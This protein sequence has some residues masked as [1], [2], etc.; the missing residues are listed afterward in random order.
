VANQS[1]YKAAGGELDTVLRVHSFAPGTQYSDHV[2]TDKVASYGIASLVALVAGTKLVKAAGAGAF[3]VLLKK[4]GVVIVGAGA[5]LL[6]WLKRL[7][8]RKSES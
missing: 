3:L 1:D 2:S 8:T 5:A 4:F 7:F 6:A